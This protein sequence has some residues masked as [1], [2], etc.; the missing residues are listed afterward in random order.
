MRPWIDSNGSSFLDPIS[1]NFVKL[2]LA[3]ATPFREATY[4][5][6]GW[7][8]CGGWDAIGAIAGE[9]K[10]THDRLELTKRGRVDTQSLASEPSEFIPVLIRRLKLGMGLPLPPESLDVL[11]ISLSKMTMEVAMEGFAQVQGCTASGRSEMLF[12]IIS[13]DVE[14]ERVTGL[15]PVPGKDRV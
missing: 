4:R 9:E 2:V 1:L 7:D 14:L 13:L 11:S 6:L 3:I 15:H 12:V 8:I 10:Y 5:L